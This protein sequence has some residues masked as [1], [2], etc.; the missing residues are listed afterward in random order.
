DVIRHAIIKEIIL[1]NQDTNQTHTTDTLR[2]LGRN[3]GKVRSAKGHLKLQIMEKYKLGPLSLRILKRLE[4]EAQPL[5][6]LKKRHSK[7]SASDDQH[8]D[9]GRG[10]CRR[11]GHGRGRKAFAL[12]KLSERGLINIVDG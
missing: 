9:R 3:L 4:Q 1:K 7:R 11:H 5:S 6:E 12:V 10:H 8:P 2:T